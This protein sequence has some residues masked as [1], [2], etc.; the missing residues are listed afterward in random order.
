M[1][2]IITFA[3]MI[4]SRIIINLQSKQRGRGLPLSLLTKFHWKRRG[5]LP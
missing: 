1:A 2:I 5:Y 3:C 4:R